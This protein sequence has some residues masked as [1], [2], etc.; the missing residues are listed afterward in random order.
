MSAA[1]TPNW[2]RAAA[3][4][5]TSTPSTSTT[6]CD[7]GD[8][9]AALVRMGITVAPSGRPSSSSVGTAGRPGFSGV[10]EKTR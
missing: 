8:A 9:A 1:L 10:L 4:A 2:A 3:F 7:A 6:N 5:P